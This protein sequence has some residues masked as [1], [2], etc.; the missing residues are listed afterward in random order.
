M[1]YGGQIASAP[2]DT[3]LDDNHARRTQFEEINRVKEVNQKLEENLLA[4]IKLNELNQAQANL[5]TGIANLDTKIKEVEL[6]KEK[7]KIE[8]KEE[9]F[10]LE[11]TK[12]EIEREKLEVKE[13][14]LEL[15]GRGVEIQRQHNELEMAKK[16]L[17]LDAQEQRLLF[18]K[19]TNEL[20]Q[21]E[22][23]VKEFAMRKENDYL[24]FELESKTRLVEL[25][26]KINIIEAKNITGEKL[27]FEAANKLAEIGMIVREQNVHIQKQMNEIDAKKINTEAQLVQMNKEKNDVSN[28]LEKLNLNKQSALNELNGILL[29]IKDEHFSNKAKELEISLI[30]KSNE[31]Q[32]VLQSIGL[33]RRENQVDTQEER[34]QIDDLY[35]R[36]EWQIKEMYGL[37]RE[38]RLQSQL[39]SEKIAHHHDELNLQSRIS[40]LQNS[41]EKSQIE[42]TGERAMRKYLN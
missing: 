15:I 4:E 18:I 34:Q 22:L 31:N 39:Q 7:K 11:K 24:R 1:K 2:F 36:N 13:N 23:S 5:N 28:M 26:E 17:A 41:L 3:S 27:K 14:K 10:G 42:L 8:I 25:G 6:S 32:I 30:H 40:S 19:M 38:N 37:Q 21:Y 12:M 29:Q 35:R 20:A 16:Q 9:K 33:A